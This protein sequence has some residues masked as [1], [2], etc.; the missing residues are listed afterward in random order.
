M[1]FYCNI[2]FSSLFPL[3]TPLSPSLA[4]LFPSVQALLRFVFSSKMFLSLV[5]TG[6]FF[7]YFLWTPLRPHHLIWSC[8]IVLF[9]CT[10]SVLC[11]RHPILVSDHW[12]HIHVEAKCWSSPVVGYS[13]LKSRPSEIN[14]TN[15]NFSKDSVIWKMM[16]DMFSYISV[17]WSLLKPQ[18]TLTLCLSQVWPGETVFPDYTSQNCT[19]WWVDEYERFFREIRH[20]ALWIVSQFQSRKTKVCASRLVPRSSKILP[21]H[22]SAANYMRRA[23]AGS[24]F[25]SFSVKMTLVWTEYWGQ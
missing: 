15:N 8:T 10:L 6:L 23:A 4:I 3:S 7:L 18:S 12:L 11:G 24:Y 1:D 22:D 9:T 16:N 19:D 20:D 14:N 2:D 21:W 25:W 13:I 17:I 5:H